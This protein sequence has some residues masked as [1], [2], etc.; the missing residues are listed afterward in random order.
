[1][2]DLIAKIRDHQSRVKPEAETTATAEGQE[3]RADGGSDFSSADTDRVQNP[4]DK[5]IADRLKTLE[6]ELTSARGHEHKAQ[7]ID[8]ETLLAAARWRE[9]QE[10]QNSAVVTDD[11]LPQDVKDLLAQ[12]APEQRR[13]LQHVTEKGV[14]ES[15]RAKQ[16]EKE[17]AELR[18]FRTSVEQ[19][20]TRDR[21]R[22][23]ERDVERLRQALPDFD[24]VITKPVVQRMDLLV[25]QG[26][27]ENYFDA[28]EQVLKRSI[29][30]KPREK[31]DPPPRE[32]REKVP[33]SQTEELVT[34]HRNIND[35]FAAAK[36]KNPDLTPGAFLGL[37]D[38]GPRRR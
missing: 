12:M 30:E 28:A 20:R 15:P 17:I 29:S 1:M 38:V 34:K 21:Q 37:P 4:N 13:L 23:A 11:D 33:E 19:D 36:K 18:E 24:A 5:A 25:Q 7:Q 14:F 32:P 16:L 10:R 8:N 6:A 3:S 26:L 9:H 2:S 31:N 22:Q 35:A 27:A